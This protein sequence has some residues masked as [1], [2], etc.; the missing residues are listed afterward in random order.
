MDI[1][2]NFL[3][4]DIRTYIEYYRLPEESLQVAKMYT[5]VYPWYLSTFI[6]EFLG[7]MDKDAST[8]QLLDFSKHVKVEVAVDVKKLIPK[9][10]LISTK[11]NMFVVCFFQFNKWYWREIEK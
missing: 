1:L 2:T 6:A 11:L 3:G 5:I 10:E 9:R 8:F 7:L 4:H